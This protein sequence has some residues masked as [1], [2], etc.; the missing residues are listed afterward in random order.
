VKTTGCPGIYIQI[1]DNRIHWNIYIYIVKTTGCTGKYIQ[2][3][4]NRMHWNIYIQE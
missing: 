1:E 3:E 4:D 2:I